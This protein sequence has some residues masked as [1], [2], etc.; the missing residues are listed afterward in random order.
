MKKICEV[1]FLFHFYFL[2][3]VLIPA[4]TNQ[5]LFLWES[6]SPVCIGQKDIHMRTFT[7]IIFEKA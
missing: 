7:L 5:A 2:D 4:T 6:L 1:Y 3:Q